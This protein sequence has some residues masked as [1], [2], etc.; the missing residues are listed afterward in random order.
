MGQFKRSKTSL[1]NAL[2]GYELLPVAVVP[3]TSIATNLTYGENL[4]ISVL[5]IANVWKYLKNYLVIILQKR[6]SKKY[7]SCFGSL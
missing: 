3:L 6:V 5:I 1:I 7:K 4:K 2:I